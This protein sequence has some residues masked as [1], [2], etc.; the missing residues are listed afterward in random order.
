VTWDHF[1][2]DVTLASALYG[3][4]DGRPKGRLKDPGGVT[5]RDA[6]TGYKLGW[7]PLS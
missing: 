1:L 6:V 7:V 4:S 2:P 3:V 5:P